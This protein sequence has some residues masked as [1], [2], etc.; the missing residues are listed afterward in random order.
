[1]NML[2]VLAGTLVRRAYFGYDDFVVVLKCGAT[3]ENA[4]QLKFHH[5]CFNVLQD[6][7]LTLCELDL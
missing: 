2:R 3:K 4:P 1:M 5:C 6:T 7:S